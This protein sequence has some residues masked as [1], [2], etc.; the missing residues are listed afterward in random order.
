MQTLLVI[1]DEASIRYSIQEV[2]ESEELR[3]RGA[4]QAVEAL[5]AV[6]EDPPDVILLDIR[7]GNRSGLELSGQQGADVGL[8]FADF[9]GQ[10]LLRGE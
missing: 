2:L 8:G 9:G 5:A 7:L 4:Q 3:V 10:S 1:D 6:R